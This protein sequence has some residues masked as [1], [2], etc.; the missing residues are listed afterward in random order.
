MMVLVLANVSDDQVT[1]RAPLIR[2]YLADKPK[3]AAAHTV[4]GTAGVQLSSRLRLA[5]RRFNLECVAEEKCSRY[6]GASRCG[7]RR[8]SGRGRQLAAGR[9]GVGSRGDKAR[10]CGRERGG[11]SVYCCYDWCNG[12]SSAGSVYCD[13]DI[14]RVSFA[15]LQLLRTSCDSRREKQTSRGGC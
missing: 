14:V 5:E 12:L 2:S 15:N 7:D 3:Y 11:S 9:E 4:V 13:P 8:A 1:I 6:P 10:R